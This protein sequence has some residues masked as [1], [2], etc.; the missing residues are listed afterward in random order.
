MKPIGK[1]L[2]VKEF[3]ELLEA[4]RTSL[5]FMEQLQRKAIGSY[6]ARLLDHVYY[7]DNHISTLEGEIRELRQST[8]FITGAEGVP[9]R[10]PYVRVTQEPFE[11]LDRGERLYEMFKQGFKGDEGKRNEANL[12]AVKNGKP[13]L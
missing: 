2:K 1:R 11:H 10:K 8:L 5:K 7:Q 9:E 12:W 4:M 6:V 3:K 13:Q